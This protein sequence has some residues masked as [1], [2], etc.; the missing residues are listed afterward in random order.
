MISIYVDDETKR[1]FNAALLKARTEYKK[2]IDSKKRITKN[3]ILNHIFKSF[4]S[5]DGESNAEKWR[6]DLIEIIQNSL[7]RN[8]LTLKKSTGK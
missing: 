4:N 7:E 2:N 1:N 5:L 3:D 6:L 8:I